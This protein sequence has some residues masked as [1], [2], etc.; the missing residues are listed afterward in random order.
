[1]EKERQVLVVFPHP[2]DEAFGVSGTIS[3]HVK[4]GTPVT[5]ACLTLGQM[6]RNLGNPPFATRESL[7]NI[8]RRELQNAA[9]V[10]GIQ[11]LR[12]MGLRDKTVEFEDD[13]KMTNMITDL[14]EELNPSLIITFYPGYS[15]HPDHDATGRAVI[16][17]V[18]KIPIEAR[19]KVHCVAFSKGHEEEIGKPDIAN[20]V[21]DVIDQKI[22]AMKAHISQT[23]WMMEERE[24]KVAEKDPETLAWLQTERFWSYPWDNDKV[25]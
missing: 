16:R 11:D 10:M 15:V 1:M 14:I 7:P 6:G 25:E 4:N 3:T 23:G 24:K 21:S 13:E 12:M 20:D 19:P 5:Y 9:E 8:R 22:G 2:D 17:A 18:R